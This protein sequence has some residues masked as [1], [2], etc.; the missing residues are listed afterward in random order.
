MYKLIALDL[1]DTLLNDNGV[2]SDANK[3]AI[4]RAEAIGIR[5]TIV[6]GRSFASTRQVLKE[7]GLNHPTISLNGAFIHDPATDQVLYS[8]TIDRKVAQALIQELQPFGVHINFYDEAQVI[9]QIHSEY[10]A[11]YEEMNQLSIKLVE[12]LLDY[13][14]S[15]H[16][17]KLLLIGEPEKLRTIREHIT[18][19]FGKDL[20]IVFSKPIF[21]EI[22]PK[23]T[24][25]GDALL[26]LAER[27]QIAPE[28]ILAMGDGENDVSMFH[29]VGMGIAMGNAR[30]AVQQEARF[31][32]LNNNDSGVAYA[33]ETFI[34]DE[35]KEE[36]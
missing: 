15:A 17:G 23:S 6:S 16:A 9:C 30:P 4:A 2:I 19:L 3:A 1:D 21:L 33:I 10:A 11:F 24:S 36:N 35:H 27:F 14:Q 34:F 20:N 8:Q 32:T 12:S 13:S 18:P 26:K 5:V 7:L 22:Y 25:K 28:E 29:K 31:V